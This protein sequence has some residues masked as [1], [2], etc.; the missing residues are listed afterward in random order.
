M[1]AWPSRSQTDHLD[2]AVGLKYRIGAA[3]NGDIVPLGPDEF[4][5]GR[6]TAG[7]EEYKDQ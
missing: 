1:F 2:T 6:G 4:G 7:G 3:I 5:G